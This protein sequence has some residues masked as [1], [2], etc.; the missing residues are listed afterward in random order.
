MAAR[1]VL[2]TCDTEARAKQW[3]GRHRFLLG[4]KRAID[5]TAAPILLALFSPLL[6]CI[7]IAI[8]MDSRGGILFL[9]P[10]LGRHG[11]IFLIFKFRTMFQDAASLGARFSTYDGDPRITRV[12]KFLRR[13]HL[14]ELPQFLNV[15]RG[16][17]SFI[18]PRPA[19][20]F[21]YDYYNDR[22]I[23]RIFCRPG[24]SGWAQI[25]GNAIDWDEKLRLDAW[26]V[27]N[28]SLRLE[29]KIALLTV[30]DI[31]LKWRGGRSTYAGNSDPTWTRGYPA[32][33][34]TNSRAEARRQS[35]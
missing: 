18:G 15:I 14:D 21:Q 35:V 34:L 8:A 10:R 26:Y 2:S 13:T 1:S 33:P 6:L 25:H 32:N 3:R 4:A 24:I 11:D 12:G 16:D 27:E 9:Q 17:M 22:E 20:P 7:A 30:K 23:M 19:L 31:A 29:M 28:I 5:M